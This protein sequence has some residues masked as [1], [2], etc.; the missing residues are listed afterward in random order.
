[1]SLSEGQKK[2]STLMDV[3]IHKLYLYEICEERISEELSGI[4]KLW[5]FFGRLE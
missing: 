5:V 2:T 1:M 3:D 4:S